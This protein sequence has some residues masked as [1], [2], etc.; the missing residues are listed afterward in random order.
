VLININ[1]RNM[2]PLQGIV[3]APADNGLGR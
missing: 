1:V 2:I 3:P